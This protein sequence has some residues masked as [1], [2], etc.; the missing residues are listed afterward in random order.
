MTNR[1]TAPARWGQGHVWFT[2]GGSP[3]DSLWPGRKLPLSFL[4]AQPASSPGQGAAARG[5]LLTHSLRSCEGSSSSSR[6]KH[7][8]SQ[9]EKVPRFEGSQRAEVPSICPKQSCAFEPCSSASRSLSDRIQL[10]RTGRTPWELPLP[11][12]LHTLPTWP[13]A[14]SVLAHP[15]ACAR[16]KPTPQ[17]S[18]KALSLPLKL[19]SEQSW[20]VFTWS[21]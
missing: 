4:P 16:A 15:W 12:S 6:R 10:K 14:L 3:P 2:T 5:R 13:G 8:R 21:L 1:V 9:L 19:V 20:L 7:Q 17:S 11:F 18:P